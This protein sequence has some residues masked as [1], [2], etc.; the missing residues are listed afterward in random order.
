MGVKKDMIK[1]RLFNLRFG[2]YAGN[3]RLEDGCVGCIE[4]NPGYRRRFRLTDMSTD[5]HAW[6]ILLSM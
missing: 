6:S 5:I 1:E 2:E 3:C 4:W